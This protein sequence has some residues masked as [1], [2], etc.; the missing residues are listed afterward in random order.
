MTDDIKP[1]EL[2][3]DESIQ[4]LFNVGGVLS[5]EFDKAMELAS[6]AKFE[7]AAQVLEGMARALKHIAGFATNCYSNVYA[8]EHKRFSWWG[9]YIKR[10]L[11]SKKPS[12]LSKILRILH[13]GGLN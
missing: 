13:M 3:F 11:N 9:T 10:N 8:N 4:H 6:D 5:S 7:E 12:L 2:A 1:E